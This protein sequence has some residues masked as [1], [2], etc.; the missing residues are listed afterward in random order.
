[1]DAPVV[2]VE[3]NPRRVRAVFAG[4]TI[5]DSREALVLHERGHKPVH[6]IPL[7]DVRTDL[8][9]PSEHHTTCPRKGLASY[10]SIRVGDHV[11]ENAVWRYEHPIESCP[12]ISQHV[13][14]Y[15]NR[16]DSLSEH[17]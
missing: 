10:Y 14:F 16:I 9:E 7:T 2:T 17:N 12:D 15:A 13:A 11:A 1:M 5:A 3:P 8:L 6:Y 4:E